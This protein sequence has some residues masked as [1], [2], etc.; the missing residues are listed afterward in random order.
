MASESSWDISQSTIAV[1]IQ[2]P[3]SPPNIQ[4]ADL[5][6]LIRPPYAIGQASATESILSSTRDQMEI[7]LSPS[8][9]NVRDTSGKDEFDDS[10]VPEILHWF[11][12]KYGTPVRSFGI[13]FVIL[14]ENPNPQLWIK[15]VLLNPSIE[16]KSGLNLLGGQARISLQTGQKTWNIGFQQMQEENILELNFNASQEASE[17][18]AIMELQQSMNEQLLKLKDLM[19]NLIPTKV[20][21]H[22]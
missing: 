11:V 12:G 18:P 1:V 22:G 19:A 13:N 6:S 14:L 21:G 7:I 17:L 2:P 4:D 20:M 9:I 10:R 5:R 8:K 16:S 15:E 3:V